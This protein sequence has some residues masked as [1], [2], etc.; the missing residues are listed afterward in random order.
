[1]T[2]REMATTFQQIREAGRIGLAAFKAMRS[3]LAFWTRT[4]T[5]EEAFVLTKSISVN[6]DWQEELGDGELG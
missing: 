6:P 5:L 2:I 1:M 4:M 3:G